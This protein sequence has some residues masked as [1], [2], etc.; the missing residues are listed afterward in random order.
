MPDGAVS[1]DTPVREVMPMLC[2]ALVAEQQAERF[3]SSGGRGVVMRFGLRDGPGT[4]F[5]CPWATSRHA[6]R[7]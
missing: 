4:W 2:S 1:E 3:A 5:D 6:A 7:F